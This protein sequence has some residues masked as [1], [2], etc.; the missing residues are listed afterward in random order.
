MSIKQ[1]WNGFIVSP[2][3]I[4]TDNKLDNKKG[5]FK[6]VT[7]TLIEFIFLITFFPLTYETNDNFWM[8]AIASGANSGSPSEYLVFINIFIGKILKLFYTIIPSINW[9]TIYILGSLFV[10]YTVIQFSFYK[11]KSSNTI[12]VIRHVF[13]FAVLFGTLIESGF[14]RTSMI[15]A[16]GG[17]MLI[18]INNRKN[19][20][21]LV[22]GV[23]LIILA[24]MMRIA[25]FYMY[26]ALSF[27][28]IFL[29]LLKRKYTQVIYVLASFIIALSVFHFH[30]QSINQNPEFTEFRKFNSTRGKL[31]GSH[32]PF[33]NYS[34]IKDK[35][36]SA[37][38]TYS[39]YRLIVRSAY[40]LGHD[41]F[42][43]EKLKTIVPEKESP[44]DKTLSPHIIEAFKDT[45]REF[46]KYLDMYYYYVIPLIVI[47]LLLMG[48]KPLQVAFV[49]LYALFV[50]L[51]A[52]YLYYYREGMLKTR[53]MF[54]L[55]LPA[56]LLVI[57]CF[58]DID[59]FTKV[60]FLS[61]FTR[62]NNNGFI[63]INIALIT[64]FFTVY[65]NKENSDATYKARDSVHK[66]FEY[67]DRQNHDFYVSRLRGAPYYIYKNPPDQSNAYV[68]GWFV[69][70][71]SN[72]DKIEKYT[73]NRDAGIYTIY[74]K[75]IIMYFDRLHYRSQKAL[76]IQ[77]YQDNYEHF[78]VQSNVIDIPGRGK[79]YKYTFH[80]T[81]LDISPLS[82]LGVGMRFG[83][84]YRISKLADKG[85]SLR[86]F[87]RGAGEPE[88]PQD[89]EVFEDLE[90]PEE[91][92]E[93]DEE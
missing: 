91:I 40:D 2:F 50:L 86:M 90:I 37:G 29:F 49:V 59:K 16:A 77:F 17:F 78:T 68:L 79:L 45:F 26:A 52:F 56:I 89:M 33:L 5:F 31:M 57:Y 55:T 43:P 36:E 30:K 18:F 6:V 41:K 19:H 66:Y 87:S 92:E 47:F 64:L 71:P 65:V 60:S 10:G 85:L 51:L 72:K 80:I 67:I 14:T 74:N 35:V 38:Y 7:I 3:T 73:G 32:N 25:A 1:I 82:T 13:V 28:F 81:K 46:W 88:L 34:D 22:L 63:F 8:N 61:V 75:D 4:D 12:R 54:G 44:A 76:I 24:S 84:Q 53:V 70:S 21:Q 9:Y 27:P 48:Q 20:K 83:E 69:G 15:L 93:Y 58:D 42:D 39:D 23:I 11:L 62:S